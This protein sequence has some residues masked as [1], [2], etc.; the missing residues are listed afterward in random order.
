MKWSKSFIPTL[1][2]NP[3]D[4]EATSHKLMF[5]AGLIRRVTAGAYT[6]LPLGL[7]ALSKA[8]NIVREEMNRAG[9][10]ELLMPALQPPE[11]WKKTGRY[12]VIGDVMIK[13]ET[14]NPL[15]E[16]KTTIVDRLEPKTYIGSGF[17]FWVE[18]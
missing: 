13:S 4:A 3:Q 7:K 16:H 2:E 10:T 17:S 5:R 11:L 8:E 18:D 1:K 14:V 12:D 6:Y 15:A 9:A